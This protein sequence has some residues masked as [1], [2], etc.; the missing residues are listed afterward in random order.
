MNEKKNNN[1][2]LKLN[3]TK[4]F[5]GDVIRFGGLSGVICAG[6]TLMTYGGC[7]HLDMKVIAAIVGGVSLLGGVAGG[8]FALDDMRA[9]EMKQSSTEQIQESGK[10]LLKK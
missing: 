5:V 2:R 9:E 7:A 1:I 4:H 3:K 8:I 10:V 6:P